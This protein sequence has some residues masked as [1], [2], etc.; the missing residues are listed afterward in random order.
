MCPMSMC[1]H[2]LSTTGV[3]RAISVV[4]AMDLDLERPLSSITTTLALAPLAPPTRGVVP[5]EALSELPPPSVA[6]SPSAALT[7]SA[8]IPTAALGLSEEDPIP[9]AALG[10]SE[11]RIP[12]KEDLLEDLMFSERPMGDLCLAPT[13]QV[14]TL[15]FQRVPA[16]VIMQ[17]GR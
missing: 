4:T 2:T 7:L 1:P 13:V 8:P 6:P 12:S 15:V 10:L 14:G 11:D 9:T 3:V 5:V 16:Q 17:L